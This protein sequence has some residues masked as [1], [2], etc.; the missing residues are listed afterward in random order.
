MRGFDMRRVILCL[1]ILC[2]PAAVT[3]GAV[4][5]PP[6]V[7][8]QP[9][10][11][12]GGAAPFGADLFQGH[13][14][15]GAYDELNSDYVIMPGD[16]ITVRLWGAHKF[17]GVLDV[18]AQGNLFLPEVGP[19]PVAGLRHAQLP[20]VVAERVRSV[21]TNNVEVY[22]NLINTQPVALYVTGF[23][24]RPGR[25]A[26]GSTD[27]VLYY[28]D[29]AGGIDA[30]RG[31]FRDIRILRN[32]R[33]FVHVDLY[34]FILDG[35][36]PRPRLEE[37][38]VILVGKRGAGILAQRKVRHSA[39]FEFPA[40][41]A[42]TGRQLT[43]LATPLHKVSHV[44]VVGAR[45]GAP[46]N[47]YVS[48]EEFQGVPL[49]DGDVVDFHAD[50]PGD[51]IMVAATGAIVGPS[52]YPVK[53]DTRLTEL[54]YHI[55]VEPDLANRDGIHVKR[56]SVAEQQKKALEESLRRLEETSLTAT[57]QSV[58]EANIRVREAELIAQFV[59]KARTVEPDGTVVV[60]HD[61]KLRDI[62]LEDGDV[63]V[64]PAKSDVVLISGEVI[65]PQAV[66]YSQGKNSRDYIAVAGGFSH[67]ADKRHILVAKPN[68]EILSTADT[69]IAP[70][71]HVMVLPRFDTKNRQTLKDISQILY[72]IAIATK[73]VLDL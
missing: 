27:S 65:M 67:R 51:T 54:L 58:D 70:G 30:E 21:Y 59:S 32:G 4:G 44:S 49:K 2:L 35:S 69:E 14:A 50:T 42:I 55:P 31:S 28:L 33:V 56:K 6:V 73:V 71:D 9:P 48:V 25:Y 29:Q 20:H 13:F 17:D 8:L 66:V 37:G 36:L 3:L 61:G 26:G 41:A 64:I 52:R 7:E 68:G 11:S 39:R 23:V 10:P 24:T 60:G 5:T 45:N 18:D 16:R 15:K 40:D 63:V 34:P 22:T 47:T 53:K 1:L 62:F 72:Q 38:D 57:S 43:D 12:S 46:F 19:V